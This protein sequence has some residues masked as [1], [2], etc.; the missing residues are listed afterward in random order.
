MHIG[1]VALWT[2]DLARAAA[3]W[4]T[5]FNAQVGEEYRSARRKGFA[6][7]FVNLGDKGSAALELMTGPWL[8]AAAEPGTERPGWAHVAVSLG[9]EEAV[10]ALAGRLERDGLLV[11]PP[12]WTGDGFYE[13][14]ARDPDGNLIEITS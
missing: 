9:S 4:E 2:H 3:F 11:A 1:H 13:T 14:V 8:P 5:Y 6:S 10:R 7:R 12:R